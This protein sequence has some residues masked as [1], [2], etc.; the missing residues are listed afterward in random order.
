MRVKLPRIIGGGGN[1]L[2]VLLD[3]I[4][5]RHNDLNSS[6]YNLYKNISILAILNIFFTICVFNPF[7]LYSS[8][9]S[10]FD[11]AQTPQ[12]LSA[13]FGIF[14]LLSLS[15]I[16]LTS[17]F[18]RT[19]LLKIGVFAFSVLF[20][21]AT[22]YSFF[23][24]KNIF[25]GLPYAQIDGLLFKDGGAN[26]SHLYARYFDVGFCAF[27]C[28]VVAAVLRLFRRIF[29]KILW[30]L[31]FILIIS[32]VFSLIKIVSQ[33][34]ALTPQATAK[35]QENKPSTDLV[36]S[37]VTPYLSF[38]KDKNILVIMS[39]TV[40]SDNFAQ[41][42][43]DYPEFSEIFSGFTYYPNA[44]S[45]GNITFAS[46]PSIVGGDYYAPHN[47]NAR[48]LKHSLA[49]E[50]TQAFVG[51][52]NAFSNAGYSVALGTTFPADRD[53]VQKMLN[54]DVFVAPSSE[55]KD[56]VNFYKTT[57][58]IKDLETKNSLPIGDLLSF[59]LF[60]AAPYIFRTRIYQ[61]EGWIFGN[62]LLNNHYR[63]SVNNAAKIPSFALLSNTDSP[64]PTFKFLYE[65]TEHF[66]WVLDKDNNCK[67]IASHALYREKMLSAR[68]E[69]AYSNH[70]CYVRNLA[71]FIKWLKDSNI[72]DNTKIIIT[73]DH[74]NGGNGAPIIDF[75]IRAARY[76]HILLLVK[77][78]HAKGA[79]NIDKE[80]LVSNADVMPLACD[81][82]ESK[83]PNISPSFIKKPTKNR[84]LFFNIVDGGSGRESNAKYD[85]L[86][87][88]SVK[89][90]IFNLNNWQEVQR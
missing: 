8:D 64:K 13:L 31:F 87:T 43:Q 34:H 17:F 38:S 81:E 80:T 29:Y 18:Y 55:P 1:S 23:L 44:L 25:N 45:V 21:I 54:K 88:Y 30:F 35:N 69:L 47:V 10:Q 3:A 86:K 4:F 89:N 51:I 48:G 90:S 66:P 53:L 5:T 7:A 76:S 59:G 58:H 49:T 27:L 57:F 28:A 37:Y 56:F 72:Y 83:C 15:T 36:P 33:T 74:G 52:A 26:I 41:A 12:T 82:I 39:D 77:D 70:T 84:E 9:V 61:S 79:I 32:S 22:I 50:N 2:K 78:F 24:M 16:Y 42:L 71:L 73:S 14:I 63:Y 85:I 67:P 40:Q 6:D 68:G 75:P 62:S 65:G 60:R 46:M 20:S 19:R 11:A